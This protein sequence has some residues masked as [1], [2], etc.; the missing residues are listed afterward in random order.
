MIYLRVLILSTVIG[1]A[2]F[3]MGCNDDRVEFT[4]NIQTFDQVAVQNNVFVELVTI[5]RP[6]WIVIHEDIAG[7]AG[8]II[9]YPIFI[10]SAGSFTNTFVPLDSSAVL[11][12]SMDVMVMLYY[13]NGTSG[14]FDQEDQPVTFDGQPVSSSIELNA[15]SVT[16]NNQPV[17]D[18]TV[19]VE[20]VITGILSWVAIY[21]SNLQGSIGDLV[22][23]EAITESPV[24][25]LQVQL[26]DTVDYVP[27][28]SLI[29]VLHLNNEPLNV[30]TPGTDVPLVFGFD[31]DNEI[32]DM[33][34]IE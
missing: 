31:D 12:E 30:F 32:T 7:S 33:F 17:T 29:A 18:H 10:G 11:S 20:Q 3:M 15:P 4:P 25:N 8:D 28:T 24:T 22:G 16:V 27:G 6:G 2:V 1:F 9:S 14:V 5:D 34:L 23:F 26:T 19:V 13:D 21:Q